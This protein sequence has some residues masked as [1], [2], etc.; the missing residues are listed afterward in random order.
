M[1]FIRLT[2]RDFRG[3]DQKAARAKHPAERKKPG[4]TSGKIL[5]GIRKSGKTLKLVKSP[6]GRYLLIAKRYFLNI[7][8]SRHVWFYHSPEEANRAYLY[9]KCKMFKGRY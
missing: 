8:I 7:R 3:T 1:E 5:T 4:Y 9:R 6:G 2:P